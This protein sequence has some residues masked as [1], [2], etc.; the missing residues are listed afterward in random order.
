ML[1]AAGLARSVERLTTA[2]TA[3]G[4]R[5]DS[6]DRINTQGLTNGWAF[7]SLGRQRKMEALSLLGDVKLCS[8]LVL[9]C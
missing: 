2:G 1:T 4:R 6:R 9:S 7:V 5:F 8:Q 3:G